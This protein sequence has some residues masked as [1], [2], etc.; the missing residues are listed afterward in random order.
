MAWPCISRACCIARFWNQLD[1]ADIAVPLVFTKYSE[2]TDGATPH[3]QI[4]APGID[5]QP[6]GGDQESVAKTT[7]ASEAA[8]E[9]V[10][11]SVS[12]K[13]ASRRESVMRQDYRPW[14]VRPEPSCKP[15]QEYTPTDTPFEKETQYKKDF[16]AWPIPKRSDHH[17]WIP[18]GERGS[19]TPVPTREEP[20]GSM[21]TPVALPAVGH[22]PAKGKVADA[23][24]RQI[25]EERGT[26][27][28]Y[29]NEF[30]P[31][32][33]D[34]KPTKIVKAKQLYHPPEAKVAHE[35]SYNTTFRGQF[36]KRAEII[37]P[38]T[39]DTKAPERRKMR[40]LYSEA[41]KEPAKPDKPSTQST[42]PK[43][44][45]SHKVPKKAKEKQSTSGR[46]VK[47]KMTDSA[48]APKPE[49]EAKSQEMNNKLAEA[50]E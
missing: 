43:K 46:A 23:L 34:V 38:G 7:E 37:R 17:P 47:K 24:N 9:V 30:R 18:K 10:S 25:K 42:K 31:W 29:R 41:Y 28:S 36:S 35:T 48:P 26:S 21:A 33:V 13:T 20:S 4:R 11:A 6:T 12:A 5:A 1:K 40:S 39:A 19:Q 2:V 3:H 8:T 49:E 44:P 22:D 32:T 50:K 45:S 27:T 16:K 15:K 14:K